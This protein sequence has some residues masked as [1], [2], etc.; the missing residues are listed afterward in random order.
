MRPSNKQSAM[1]SRSLSK[2]KTISSPHISI[3]RSPKLSPQCIDTAITIRR[4]DKLVNWGIRRGYLTY[5][6]RD[7]VLR[8]PTNIGIL[9]RLYKLEQKS[10]DNADSKQV[11][12]LISFPKIYRETVHNLEQKIPPDWTI[13]AITPPSPLRLFLIPPEYLQRESSLVMVRAVNGLGIIDESLFAKIL[14]ALPIERAMITLH[15]LDRCIQQWPKYLVYINT[16]S[17]DIKALQTFMSPLSVSR[18]PLSTLLKFQPDLLE[19]LENFEEDFEKRMNLAARFEQHASMGINGDDISKW[20]ESPAGVFGHMEAIIHQFS[21][22][23]DKVN[24]ILKTIAA[25]TDMPDLTKA[26]LLLRICRMVSNGQLQLS[27]LE[28]SHSIP[29]NAMAEMAL[30]RSSIVFQDVDETTESRIVDLAKIWGWDDGLT[31]KAIYTLHHNRKVFFDPIPDLSNND[32]ISSLKTKFEKAWEKE[33]SGV[34]LLD[35]E[36]WM[37]LATHLSSRNPFDAISLDWPERCYIVWLIDQA[38]TKEAL[39]LDSLSDGLKTVEGMDRVF[40]ELATFDHDHPLFFDESTKPLIK[41]LFSQSPEK[42]LQGILILSQLWVG[43]RYLTPGTLARLLDDPDALAKWCD[44]HT[45]TGYLSMFPARYSETA[46]RLFD[47]RLL[48]A[49]SAATIEDAQKAFS[50]PEPS[51]SRGKVQVSGLFKAYIQDFGPTL[52]C[53]PQVPK[54]LGE[55]DRWLMDYIAPDRTGRW[56][57]I[58]HHHSIDDKKRRKVLDRKEVTTCVNIIV[59][60]A[61]DLIND[62]FEVVQTTD[63]T[64]MSLRGRLLHAQLIKMYSSLPDDFKCL[65]REL[66]ASRQAARNSKDFMLGVGVRDL[67]DENGKL[68]GTVQLDISARLRKTGGYTFLGLLIE[69]IKTLPD[70]AHISWKVAAEHQFDQRID[71]FAETVLKYSDPGPYGIITHL[72]QQWEHAIGENK[73][74]SR[75]SE[76]LQREGHSINLTEMSDQINQLKKWLLNPVSAHAEISVLT[77]RIMT[78]FWDDLYQGEASIQMM[79]QYGILRIAHA[80]FQNEGELVHDSVIKTWAKLFEQEYQ[81]NFPDVKKGL[82]GSF[83]EQE[84][85]ITDDNKKRY[86]QKMSELKDIFTKIA[87]FA[88]ALPMKITSE[89]MQAIYFIL[90]QKSM[91]CCIEPVLIHSLN[92]S[93]T[94][95]LNTNSRS[96]MESVKIDGKT[97]YSFGSLLKWQVATPCQKFCQLSGPI[98]FFFGEFLAT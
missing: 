69:R 88:P 71:S 42:M 90:R 61:D 27:E 52:F 83:F 14:Q 63:P 43:E 18:D 84:G 53:S 30:I 1:T 48:E 50:R 64:T 56:A 47:A 45:Q 8:D 33:M 66:H 81:S 85:V 82:W 67:Q 86:R 38:L 62:L 12:T 19:K 6:D 20:Q 95:P 10:M 79:Y 49:S 40:I 57:H 72:K 23:L 92:S 77:L 44:T 58:A 16:I 26:K 78:L 5:V 75:I 39:T 54:L 34:G 73:R 22:Q 35:P 37:N 91:F 59:N 25:A 7:E 9:N 89:Q 74:L 97:P 46:T 80:I 24:P 41:C 13:D 36:E 2:N 21:P 31:L 96:N 28:S 87:G 70:M 17:E 4:V 15:A 76:Q 98:Q 94:I 65:I 3:F 93:E 55:W 51:K 29:T 32:E 60:S 11:G 68:S